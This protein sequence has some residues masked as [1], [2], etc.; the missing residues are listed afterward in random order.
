MKRGKK[1]IRNVSIIAILLFLFCYFGGYFISKEACI[2]D[3]LRG[4]HRNERDI[5]MELTMG[6]RSYTVVTDMEEK[7]YSI[8]GTKRIGFLY[9]TANSYTGHEIKEEECIDISGMYSS[10]IGSLIFVHRNDERIAR[11]EMD[12]EDGSVISLDE[13][14]ND[15]TGIILEE[16]EW[17]RGT[18]KAYDASNQLIGEV[19]Y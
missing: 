12:L 9:H 5:A 1:L 13:W 14:E 18:Y 3:S 11:V 10:E 17:Y 6:N 15:F 2:V 16:K 19:Y 7:V 4:L 8:I